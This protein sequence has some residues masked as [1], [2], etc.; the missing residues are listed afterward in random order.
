MRLTA[1]PIGIRNSTRYRYP[2]RRSGKRCY[3]RQI[4][5]AERDGTA[6]AYGELKRRLAATL[7]DPDSDPNVNDPTADL[8]YLAAEQWAPLGGGKPGDGGAR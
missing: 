8:V 6:D 3:R 5:V 4:T 2:P 1:N 7:A